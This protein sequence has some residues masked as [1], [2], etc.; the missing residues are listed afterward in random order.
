MDVWKQAENRKK[1]PQDK[2]SMITERETAGYT[3]RRGTLGFD[4]ITNTQLDIIHNKTQT[5]IHGQEEQLTEAPKV[6]WSIRI[7]KK[8]LSP[9]YGEKC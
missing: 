2:N 1:T 7:Y 8:V 9:H 6:I 4:C 3:I 5:D